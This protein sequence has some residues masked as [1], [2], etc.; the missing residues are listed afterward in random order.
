MIFTQVTCDHLMGV[1]F[2]LFLFSESRC[3]E[4]LLSCQLF[5]ASYNNGMHLRRCY[6]RKNGKRHEYQNVL[7]KSGKIFIIF[8]DLMIFFIGR[9]KPPNGRCAEIFL[10]PGGGLQRICHP[11]HKLLLRC[12]INRRALTV[13]PDPNNYKHSVVL[14]H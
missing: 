5:L 10:K 1:W 3:S 9:L 6:R 12:G 8:C 13:A 2:S 4:D 11:S 14:A 7:G